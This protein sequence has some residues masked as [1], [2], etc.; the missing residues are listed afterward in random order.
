[1]GGAIKKRGK[2]WQV[3]IEVGRDA[4]GR[5]IRKSFTARTR[6]EAEIILTENKHKIMVGDFVEPSRMTFAEFL[7]HW[8]EHYVETNCE[9]TTRSGYEKV[10]KKHVIPYLGAI[11]L[12]K[13]SPMHIQQYYKHLMDVKRLSPNTVR[14]QHS[15]IRKS[16]D[17][18]FKMQ[19]INKNPADRV[20]LL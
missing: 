13:L 2:S 20:S 16:L 11:P 3:M 17:Y 18:A 8:M 9:A 6:E 14:R 7:R 15:T 19:L 1:M 12:Q 10:I 5:R 4:Y